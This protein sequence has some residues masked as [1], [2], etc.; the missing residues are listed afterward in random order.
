MMLRNGEVDGKRL[1][2][3]IRL[4]HQQKHSDEKLVVLISHERGGLDE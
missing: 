4:K 2:N 3:A 1:A